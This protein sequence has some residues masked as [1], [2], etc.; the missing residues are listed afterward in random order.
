MGRKTVKLAP[1]ASQ[2]CQVA[3]AMGSTT[4]I[5]HPQTLMKIAQLPLAM[6]HR[7]QFH[8]QIPWWGL[9]SVYFMTC[10]RISLQLLTKSIAKASRGDL[11]SLELIACRSTDLPAEAHRKENCHPRELLQPPLPDQCQRQSLHHR[12]CPP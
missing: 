9:V 3:I 4:Q 2:C 5:P 1:R 10:L 7:C 12:C 8:P 11:A 6:Q